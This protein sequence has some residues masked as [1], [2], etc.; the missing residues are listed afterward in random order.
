MHN[1]WMNG[2]SSFPACRC[3]GEA[4]MFFIRAHPETFRCRKHEKRNP[5]IVD[6]CSRTVTAEGVPLSNDQFICSEHWRR[7]VPPGSRARRTYNAHVRRMKKKGYTLQRHRAWIRFWD[8][9]VL[10][11]RRRSTEGRIDMAEID[12]MF[13]WTE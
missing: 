10:M 4:A 1:E 11:V 13:G 6:G 8:T 3:C 2:G 12:R 5:C 7:Y 9:L